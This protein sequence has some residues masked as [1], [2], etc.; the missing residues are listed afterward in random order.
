MNLCRTHYNSPAKKIR[1][2]KAGTI[3]SRATIEILGSSGRIFFQW[4]LSSRCDSPPFIVVLGVQNSQFRQCSGTFSSISL[5]IGPR[6]LGLKF[7]KM[8]N[9]R[10][11]ISSNRQISPKK[12]A[13]SFRQWDYSRAVKE[14]ISFL[15]LAKITEFFLDNEYFKSVWDIML[16]KQIIFTSLHAMFTNS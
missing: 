16:Q 12:S 15:N 4:G 6:D 2:Y 3:F 11:K 13:S 5:P 14:R 1:I 9:I 10:Q 7:S 8:L